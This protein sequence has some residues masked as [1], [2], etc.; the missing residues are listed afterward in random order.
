MKHPRSLRR[1][2]H[3]HGPA[4]AVAGV[5][6][7][8]LASM[9]LGVPLPV[10]LQ[11]GVASVA[12]AYPMISVVRAHRESRATHHLITTTQALRTKLDRDPL[13]GLLNRAAFNAA[14]ADLPAAANGNGHLVVVFFDLD[15]FKDVNDTLG[16]KT[17]DHLL[18][19]VAQRAGLV[20]GEAHAFARLG[21]DEFAAILPWS[22]TRRPDDYGHALVEAMN[23][24]FKIDGCTVEIAASVGIAIGDAVLDDGH[25]LLRRADVAMY[26]AKGSPRGGCRIYDDVLSGKQTREGVIRVELGNAL[27]DGA[28]ELHYQPVIDART[29]RVSSAEALLRPNFAALG[30]TTT[31]SLIAIAEASG[32]IM[33]LTEWTLDTAL[34]ATRELDGMPVAVNISPVYFRHPDFVHR[35]FDKLLAARVRPELLTVEVTEG[36]LIADIASARHS[37]SRL[38]E[39]GVRV[40]LDDF[41]TGYSSLSY[42]QHFDLD[43]LKLDKSFL[44]DVGD[45]RKATQIIRSIIDFGHSLDMRVVVEGVE[46]DWQA[47]LLQLLGCDLLQGYELGVPMPLKDFVAFTERVNAQAALAEAAAVHVGDNGAKGAT[48][49]AP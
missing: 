30:D 44:K 36:V 31:Q 27:A 29:G 2:L 6:A 26:D 39:I 24:P 22:D 46:S 33:P 1:S 35:I 17:G 23:E 41:G 13:T 45:R 38:R 7:G 5:A 43:G 12:M 19:E 49:H 25:E 10:W 42:L 16:H 21:G 37:I 40:F 47:R 34:R 15:R 32:Q 3:D 4:L 8:A 11:A 48:A 28:F 9:T 20:L 18:V 14:L